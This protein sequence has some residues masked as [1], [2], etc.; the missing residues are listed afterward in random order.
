MGEFSGLPASGECFI[1]VSGEHAT[2]ERGEKPP[3]LQ[4]VTVK[5]ELLVYEGWFFGGDFG[6]TSDFRV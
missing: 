2:T 4:Q 3:P 5:R 6:V 1:P